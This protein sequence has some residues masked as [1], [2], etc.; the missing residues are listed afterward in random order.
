[1]KVYHF[2]PENDSGEHAEKTTC[3]CD[4]RAEIDK[5]TGN[6]LCFHS[7]FDSRDL[8][9]SIEESEDLDLRFSYATAYANVMFQKFQSGEITLEMLRGSMNKLIQ[10]LHLYPPESDDEWDQFFD[11]FPDVPGGSGSD[12]WEDWSAKNN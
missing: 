10:S 2:F 5:R 8:L 4:P 1:M 12:F 11:D 3:P 9:E 6:I 7:P